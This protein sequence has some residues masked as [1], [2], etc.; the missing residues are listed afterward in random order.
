MLALYVLG[1]TGDAP[2]PTGKD[3]GIVVVTD[4]PCDTGLGEQPDEDHLIAYPPVVVRTVPQ[5]GDQAVDP[6]LTRIEVTFSRDMNEGSWSWVQISDELYPE[7]SEA[8]FANERKA[9]LVVELEPASNYVVWINH[10]AYNNFKD[11]HGSGAVPYQLA[12]R[13]ASE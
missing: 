11:T 2:G 8:Y 3:T 5:A 1:C 13:T 9:V 7:S 6:S 4:A 10:D 12:F